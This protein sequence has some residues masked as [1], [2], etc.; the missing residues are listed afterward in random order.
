MAD[1]RT[2]LNAMVNM[3]SADGEIMYLRSEIKIVIWFECSDC[4]W[5]DD[6]IFRA[7]KIFHSHFFEHLLFGTKRLHHQFW[8]SSVWCFHY[9]KCSVRS[10]IRVCACVCSALAGWWTGPSW[11][12]LG[13]WTGVHYCWWLCLGSCDRGRETKREEKRV[14][15]SQ[16]MTAAASI[17]LSTS[18]LRHFSTRGQMFG[19]VCVRVRVDGCV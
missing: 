3:N 16:K 14:R 1:E 6:D 15:E 11:N 19:W 17:T 2:I 10:C 9:L 5:I 18:I 4:S 13:I 7:S 8:S 12:A